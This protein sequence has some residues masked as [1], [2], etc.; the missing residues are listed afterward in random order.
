M[1]P[2]LRI[3]PIGGV[4][5]AIMIVVLALNP[6]GE[7]AASRPHAAP[8]ARGALVDAGA[9]PEWRHFLIHAAIRRADELERLRDLPDTPVRMPG[10][11]I[12]KPEAA[13]DMAPPVTDEPPAEATVIQTPVVETPAA[14]A[15]AEAP[16]AVAAI[17][18]DQGDA[19]TDDQTGSVDMT[20]ETPAA[21]DIVTPAIELPVVNV[22]T[23]LPATLPLSVMPPER[24][25][26]RTVTR[27]KPVRRIR[28]AA[29]AAPKPAPPQQQTQNIFE[30]L[31]GPLQKPGQTNATQPALAG[32]EPPTAPQR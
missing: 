2:L 18:A 4:F 25:K 8:L 24:T 9:H 15:P 16:V 11:T 3:I 27:T 6:P 29:R 28:R 13:T 1:L 10:V 20:P 14:G 32:S 23:A 12:D 30:L 31:F 22:P 17:P 21:V 19:E 7:P 26:P 5:F